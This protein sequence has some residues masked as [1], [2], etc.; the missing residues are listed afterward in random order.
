M[1]IR[2][3]VSV[4]ALVTVVIFSGCTFPKPLERDEYG[5][6]IAEGYVWCGAKQRCIKPTEE[7]CETEVVEYCAKTGSDIGINVSEA[8]RIALESE[9]GQSE[10]IE[11][12]YC[13][14]YTG[15]WW[16]D[17]EMEKPGCRPACV[18]DVETGEAEINWRC[19]GLIR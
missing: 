19:T 6:V 14:E 15:T 16:I 9:C 8:Q 7:Q 4:L 3:V 10:L 11:P 1:L 13:N 18:I 17:L 2:K 12:Y 5:C